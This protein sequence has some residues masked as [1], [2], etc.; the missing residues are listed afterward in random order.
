MLYVCS[1]LEMPG[2][3]RALR[4]DHLVS[5]LPAAEQPPTPEGFPRERHHR[6][7]IDDISEAREGQVVPEVR[8]VAALI[9]YLRGCGGETVL[10]HCMAGISRSTAAALI[11]LAIEDAG[12]ETEHCTRLRALA[13]HAHPNRRMIALA[14]ELLA[15]GGRLV[16]AREAMGPAVPLLTAPLVRLER[17]RARGPRPTGGE[18]RLR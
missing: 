18:T 11:A 7:Q 14:D 2:H 8:H 4:P 5:L 13:P 9:E 12:R 15:C 3:V 16:A 1:L 10:F 6:V 17:A